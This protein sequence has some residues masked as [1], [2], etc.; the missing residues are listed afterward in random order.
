MPAMG[1]ISVSAKP[2]FDSRYRVSNSFN[3]YCSCMVPKACAQNHPATRNLWHI[4]KD[5]K[6]TITIHND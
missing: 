2:Q 4:P 6:R 1:Y 5:V 3:L